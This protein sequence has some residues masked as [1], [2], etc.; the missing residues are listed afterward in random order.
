MMTSEQNEFEERFSL[1]MDYGA[2]NDKNWRSD[3][4]KHRIKKVLKG[5]QH[6][7]KDIVHMTSLVMYVQLKKDR[8]GRQKEV[9]EVAK[10]GDINTFTVIKSDEN[11]YVIIDERGVTLGYHYRIKLNLFKTLEE[12]TANL[13]CTGVN[14]GKRGNYPICHYIVWRD[15]SKESYESTDY[16]KELPASKE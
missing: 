5:W 16:Q 3:K 14:A 6:Q 15:Y 9:L 7:Q 1:L 2:M 4:V 11:H 13:P 8:K 12:M 10:E